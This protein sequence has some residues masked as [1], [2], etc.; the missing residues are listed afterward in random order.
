MIL[1]V[2][3]TCWQKH[4]LQWV[5]QRLRNV[6]HS[7]P[8]PCYTVVWPGTISKGLWQFP[9]RA[10]IR[11]AMKFVPS[12]PPEREN[13]S[14]GFSKFIFLFFILKSPLI[15]RFPPSLS[16][17]HFSFCTYLLIPFAIFK[18]YYYW[19]HS[20]YNYCKILA[21]FPVLYSASL[22][23]ILHPIVCIGLAKKSVQ[24]FP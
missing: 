22:Q 1:Y 2:Q 7:P 8:S 17:S 15:Y 16:L 19:L 21:K 12:F 5:D 18:N 20:I 4:F 24:V 10:K 3:V 14:W 6:V 9:Q 11:R 23:P 13:V